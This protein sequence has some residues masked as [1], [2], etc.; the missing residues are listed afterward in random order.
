ML[1]SPTK[2]P[3]ESQKRIT[4]ESKKL[5]YGLVTI[6]AHGLGVEGQ[7]Y[8][9][10]PAFTGDKLESPGIK[11]LLIMDIL[12]EFIYKHHRIFG[13]IDSV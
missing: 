9:S 2:T 5:E 7:S 13:S 6:Y 12:H 4:V 1:Q 10:V 8:S 3:K 11:T